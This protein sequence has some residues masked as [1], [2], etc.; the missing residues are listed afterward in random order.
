[1][2]H[3]KSTGNLVTAFPYVASLFNCIL[4]A[5]YMADHAELFIVPL[6]VNCT[7]ILLNASFVACY[8][9][10]A[11][12][13]QQRWVGID[14]ALFSLFAVVGVALGATLNMEIIGYVGVQRVTRVLATYMFA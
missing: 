9:W 14:L 2:W 4:W 3:V 10:M 5:I 11:K 7:G 6:A 13:D 12:R 8:A 1:V